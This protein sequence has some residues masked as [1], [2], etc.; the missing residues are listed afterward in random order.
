MPEKARFEIEN[1]GFFEVQ[2]NPEKFQVDRAAT[3]QE[4]ADQGTVSG[5]EFQKI[6]PAS[7]SMEL[8]FDTTVDGADV[9]TAWVNRFVSALQPKVKFT[10]EQGS[11]QGQPLEKVRPPKV[12]FIWGNFDLEGVIE[13]LNVSYTMFAEDGTPIRA[14]VSLKMKEFKSPDRVDISGGGQGYE[15]A[16]I[17]LVQVQQGQTLSMLAGALGTSA[18]VLADM[19]GISNPLELAAGTMLMVPS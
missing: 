7:V 19:N 18:Q 12:T 1:S 2:Y 8:N 3:W 6:A 17:Q 4:A 15:I 5:L 11:G 10:T 13:S 16:K 9:R 14:K